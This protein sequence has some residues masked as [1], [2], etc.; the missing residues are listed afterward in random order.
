MAGSRRSARSALADLLGRWPPRRDRCTACSRLGSPGSPTAANCPPGLRL[1]PERDLAAALSVSRNTV[2]AAYQLLRDDGMAESRQGAATRIVPHRTTPA[3]VHR[4]NGF[5]ASLLEASALDADL[6]LATV[7][8]APQ[9]AAALADPAAVLDPAESAAVTQTSGY[10]PH[11]LPALRA[12]I[13]GHLTDRLGLPCRSRP[14]GRHDRRPAG[15][16]PAHPVRGPAGPA[17]RRRGSHLPRRA[18][19]AVPGRRP[20]DRDAGRR[21][22]GPGA[23]GA[24]GPHAPPGDGLPDPHPSQPDRPG[25]ACRAPPPRGP[26]R[27]RPSGHAVRRRHDAD[28]TAAR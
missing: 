6:S 1:P 14:G 21:W 15:P 23:A 7:D 12:A 3:A 8:C 19:R 22:P 27:R 17:G 5:F 9:V 24:R 28:R 13:A 26:A 20:G 10:F 4:A 2:A 16:G 25:H 11:G 18:R